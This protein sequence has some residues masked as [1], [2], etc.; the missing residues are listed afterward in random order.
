LQQKIYRITA[1]LLIAV[2]IV[3]AVPAA[4]LLSDDSTADTSFTITDTTGKEFTFDGSSDHIAVFG[5]AC[6]LTVLDCGGA[7]KIVATD[8]HGAESIS[9]HY[10][11]ELTFTTL[12]TATATN[13]DVLY[14]WFL[15]AVEDGSFA[16]DDTI[17]FSTYSSSVQTGG[18][19][20]RLME[21]GFTHVLFYGTMPK[22]DDLIQCVTDIAN[23][24]GDGYD[25]VKQMKYVEDAVSSTV[26]DNVTE[27][28]DAIFIWYSKVN[29][30]GAG[31]TGSLAVSLMTISG[32]NNIGYDSTSD[33]S[34]IYDKA[35]IQQ[36]L[37]DHTDAVIFLDDAYIRTYGGSLQG[38]IDDVL[39][40]DSGDF[41]IVI[42]DRT[43]NNYDP[44]SADGVWEM[45]AA[46]YPDLFTGS[47]PVYSG[48]SDNDNTMIYAAVAGI[49]VVAVAVGLVYWYKTKH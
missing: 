25:C 30:W 35:R 22:Y 3:T 32:A 13:A 2:F 39:G 48:E 18:L 20:D 33:S 43:W 49:A 23:V 27:K 10:D 24:V 42:M 44:E 7:D 45:A 8:K 4:G 15:Q 31:N 16:F 9:D 12:A 41:Q 6:T 14:T 21:A 29:G 46:L 40:G 26:V 36:L 11:D 1:L 5:Y 19:R 37:G 47:T 38:F 34:I 28:Q 17:I